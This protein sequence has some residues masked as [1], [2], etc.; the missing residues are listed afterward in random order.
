VTSRPTPR[1]IALGILTGGLG[2]GF[3]VALAPARRLDLGAVELG[4][5]AGA[6][7]AMALRE[8]RSS[9]IALEFA[10]SAIFVGLAA[11]SLRRRS[12]L[13]VSA[14]LL[15]HAAWDA[16]HHLGTL[17]TEAPGWFPAFCCAADV[18]LAIQFARGG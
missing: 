4:F 8:E 14:G 9:A 7:P 11:F 16:A 18:A 10:A 13:L 1:A 5:I 6:Y 2:A 3:G 12:R 17:G 15:A